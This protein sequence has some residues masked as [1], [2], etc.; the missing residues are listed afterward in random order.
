MKTLF[1]ECNIGATGTMLLSALY[2]ACAHKESFVEI[3]NEALAPFSITVSADAVS[4]C[5]IWG[6]RIHFQ[7]P[8]LTPSVALASQKEVPAP[9]KN[10]TEEH[11]N[12]LLAHA[13]QQHEQEVVSS[14]KDSSDE[15]DSAL[16]RT[17][18]ELSLPTP[19]KEDISAIYQV[20][21]EAVTSLGQPALMPLSLKNEQNA[22]LLA[23]IMGCALLIYMI[24]P[25]QIICS[26]LHIG[27]GFVK[28]GDAVVS[29]PA[30]VTATL[31]KNVPCYTSSI[32]G[33]L[34][35]D[36]NAAILKYFVTQFS[37]MPALTIQS[38]GYGIGT[39]DFAIANYTR[40][41]LGDTDFALA[42]V[43]PAKTPIEETACDS[44]Q[45]SHTDRIVSIACNVDDMTGE[46]LSL[47]TEILL[48]AGA[49][50][51][52]TTSIQMKKNRPGVL[53]TCLCEEADLEKFIG[54][55][56]LHTSAQEIRHQ[57]FTRSKLESTIV[58]RRSA[59][60]NI[61][62][63]KSSGYGVEKEKPDFEDLK[64]I[65]LKTG[66]TIADIEFDE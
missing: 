12:Y 51:V 41:F 49:I 25:E 30:P 20:L 54:L 4:K 62:V 57:T 66:I 10:E 29:V 48:A 22:Q 33:S 5:G 64:S 24:A 46:A 38:I 35:D 36:A 42:P 37:V 65:V 27:S 34:L 44:E 9:A 18:L 3:M 1:L 7:I 52:Y 19:V 59:Y 8:D 21:N 55:F 50:D 13:M 40:A 60:G 43:A 32:I 45:F 15:D 56:F 31:L 61:R 28:K 11:L 16:P 6:T 14:V 58:S 39:N 26:P 2:D 63:K 47:A 17:I 23:N 53:I